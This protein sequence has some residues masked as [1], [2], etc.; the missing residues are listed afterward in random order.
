MHSLPQKVPPFGLNLAG[1]FRSLITFVMT[2]G[3][4]FIGMLH[5]YFYSIAS[6]S[7]V[8]EKTT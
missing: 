5:K 7:L 8:F 2:K 1:T 3:P 6:G 4:V